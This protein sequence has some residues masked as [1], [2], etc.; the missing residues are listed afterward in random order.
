MKIRKILAIVEENTKYFDL[1]YWKERRQNPDSPD[2]NN[3][4]AR[5]RRQFQQIWFG[6]E[7]GKEC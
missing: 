2:L 5:K 3:W 4:T 1:L 7:N 6:E